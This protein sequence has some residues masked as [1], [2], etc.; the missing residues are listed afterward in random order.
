ML[1][2]KLLS[3]LKEIMQDKLIHI[4]NCLD[5]ITIIVASTDILDV[6]ENLVEKPFSFDMLI[7]I[8]AVDYLHYGLYDWETTDATSKGFARG[9]ERVAETNDFLREHVT[10]FA[11]VYHLLSLD[12]CQRIRVKTFL[13]EEEQKIDSI[14][15]IWENAN[16]YEREAFDLF[17]IVFNKHPNLTRI[18]TDYDFTDHPF[19]KDFPLSGRTEIRYDSASKKIVYEPVDLDNRE[20]IPKVFR[21][22]TRYL[23]RKK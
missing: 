16:W 23:D 21:E 17:G 3:N 11:M 10:R 13:S 1:D 2:S 22:D 5:E 20:I 6:C 18:L 8:C 15:S 4:D 9:I 12:K 19:R 14:T 7:D